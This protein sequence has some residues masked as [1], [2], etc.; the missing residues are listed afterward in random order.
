MRALL[1]AGQLLS[2]SE[3]VGPHVATFRFQVPALV[4][5]TPAL[6]VA[7]HRILLLRPIFPKE[8]AGLLL[9]VVNQVLVWLE[10]GR[11]EFPHL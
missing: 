7:F 4:H 3:N 5:E 2:A 11:Q 8:L 6:Q 9:L 10:A 1:A